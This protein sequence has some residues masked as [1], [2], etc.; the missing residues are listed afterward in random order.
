MPAPPPGPYKPWSYA[1]VGAY[2]QHNY[3]FVDT[4]FQDG[5]GEPN[6]GIRRSY[7]HYTG[8]QLRL[9]IQSDLGLTIPS[10]VKVGVFDIELAHFH[11]PEAINFSADAYYIM[12]LPPFPRQNPGNNVYIRDQAWQDAWYHAVVDGYGM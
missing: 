4:L 5:P 10:D 2:T 12:V 8:N 6:P 9:Q 7:R 11:N 3:A 1:D